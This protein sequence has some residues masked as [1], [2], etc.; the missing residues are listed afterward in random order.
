[1]VKTFAEFIAEDLNYTTS[2]YGDI[3]FENR[4][5]YYEPEDDIIYGCD[6]K[7]IDKNT[8]LFFNPR[9][10][11][12]CVDGKMTQYDECNPLLMI[13]CDLKSSE[14]KLYQSDDVFDYLENN[15]GCQLNFDMTSS[16]GKKRVQTLFDK[17]GDDYKILLIYGN[18]L[19][20]ST[21]DIIEEN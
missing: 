16:E 21:F 8:P 14:F 3:E 9:S 15:L 17:V 18:R 12:V 1:M 20:A 11:E 10:C 13:T 19:I 6:E 5:L 2:S 7:P 4:W